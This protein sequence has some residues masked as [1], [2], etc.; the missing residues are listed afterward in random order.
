MKTLIHT[1]IL[2]F[3]TLNLSA[4]EVTKEIK[5]EISTKKL[6]EIFVNNHFGDIEI[7]Q[8]D[9]ENISFEALVK[10]EAK[11]TYEADET[12]KLVD[13]SLSDIANLL[14]IECKYDGK[15]LIDNI[16]KRIDIDVDLKIKIPKKLKLKIDGAKGTVLMNTFYGDLDI[17][18]NNAHI[19]AKK[20]SG[21]TFVLK[22]TKGECEIN[23]VSDI[24]ADI[25]NVEMNIT[26]IS[27]A[28]ITASLSNISI[29][30]AEILEMNTSG[31]TCKVNYVDR[32]NG[33]SSLTK[34]TIE[35][36]AEVFDMEMKMGEMN[37]RRVMKMFSNIN[38][39]SSFTKLGF[40]FEQ[41][42]GYDLAI[43][44]NK[45]AKIDLPFKV[46]ESIKDKRYIKTTFVGD[47]TYKGSVELNI[48]SGN[49]FIQ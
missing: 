46:S 28:R 37:I 31:G 15:L 45:M 13:V 34:Y 49:L 16:F 23:F 33:K 2:I 14:K 3:T 27:T 42:A 20:I 25:K 4:V 10:A 17:T 12:L 6:T 11:S 22:Q 48:N 47:K 36:L 9:T 8:V 39:K 44:H 41:G 7:I 35:T 38:L 19:T 18:L 30:D 32:I 26:D 21:G 1:C 5:K 40:S 29:G 24:I 43:N